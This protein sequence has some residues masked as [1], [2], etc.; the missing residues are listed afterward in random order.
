MS[1][2]LMVFERKVRL[3][4]VYQ[5]DTLDKCQKWKMLIFLLF[6]AYFKRF[7]VQFPDL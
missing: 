6:V 1:S 2:G 7:Y 5:D 3:R 4:N